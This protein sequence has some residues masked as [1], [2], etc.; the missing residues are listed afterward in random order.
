[1]NPL[2]SL[3][4][5]LLRCADQVVAWA[6]RNFGLRRV[7]ILRSVLLYWVLGAVAL[8]VLQERAS[9]FDYLFAGMMLFLHTG[10]EIA[11]VRMTPQMLN[12]VILRRREATDMKFIRMA[13]WLMTVLFIP[14]TIRAADGLAETLWGVSI[15]ISAMTYFIAIYS[16]S[17][18]DQPRIKKE[19]SI[20][21]DLAREVA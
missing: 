19:K 2:A 21:A 5:Y 13:L 10:E 16:L 17:A 1:M 7:I 15:D 4:S 9:F 3:D 14:S 18:E 12:S 8:A 20:P 6:W 11:A